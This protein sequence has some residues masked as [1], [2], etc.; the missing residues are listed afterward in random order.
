VRD[1]TPIYPNLSEITI[2]IEKRES[3]GNALKKHVAFLIKGEDR[4]GEV[5]VW[6][7]FNEFHE[8]RLAMVRVW[9]GCLIPSLP[10]KNP[11]MKNEEEMNRKRERYLDD[12]LKK[13]AQ[14]DY[15]YYSDEFQAF[16]RSETINVSEMF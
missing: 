15:L 7:R 2:G 12:F 4:K 14:R 11:L 16:L 3:R 1:S 5:N 13:M 6:R 10:S 8:M 9:P